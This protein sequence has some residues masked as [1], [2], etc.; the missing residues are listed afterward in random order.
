MYLNIYYK[1]VL[2]CDSDIRILS[3]E[4]NTGEET[5]QAYNM[6]K[7]LHINLCLLFFI[8]FFALSLTL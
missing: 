1:Y 7:F 5:M 3:K 2:I 8:F 6:N 4:Q